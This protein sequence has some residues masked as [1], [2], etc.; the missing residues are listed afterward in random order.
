M[1]SSYWKRGRVDDDHMTHKALLRKMVKVDLY[2]K[3]I[4]LSDK[5]M[6]QINRN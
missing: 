6:V 4:M 1:V 2:E 3:E 5:Q